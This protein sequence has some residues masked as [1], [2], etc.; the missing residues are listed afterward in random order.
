V[1][2]LFQR[3]GDDL[4]RLALLL[5]A[6][7]QQAEQALLATAHSALNATSELGELELA[8]ML[9]QALPAERQR[10][11]RSKRPTWVGMA[12][13]KPEQR[14]LLE[15]LAALPRAQRLVLGL[16]L[17][18]TFEVNEVA[19]LL[20]DNQVTAQTHYRDALVALL[21]HSSADLHPDDLIGD[22][23]PQAC[24]TT[25][26]ALMSG[27][28]R[29]HADADVRG[30]L[31]LCA[32]CREF[33]R[34]WQILTT[35]VEQVL[36]NALRERRLPQRLITQFHH[37]ELLRPAWHSNPTVRMILATLIVLAIIAA[38]MFPYG[39]QGQATPVQQSTN[40][41]PT[42]LTALLERAQQ[43]LYQLTPGEGVWHGRYSIQWWFPSG[44]QAMLD[45]NLWLE[46]STGRHRIQ[47]VHSSGGGPYEFEL[48]DGTGTIWY[49]INS[50][51]APSIFPFSY[52][53]RLTMASIDSMTEQ[54]QEML[55][56]RLASGPWALPAI[57][58]RQ[59]LAA[60][61]LRLWGR[62][63]NENGSMNSL[64]SFVSHSPLDMP[65]GAQDADVGEL[66]ILLTVDENT[67]RLQEI[68]ELYGPSGT[69]Q[70]IRSVWRIEE[71][72]WLPAPDLSLFNIGQAWNGT[73]TF[74]PLEE[75][76]HPQVPLQGIW[77]LSNVAQLPLQEIVYLPMF[78]QAPPGTDSA[79]LLQPNA[80]SDDLSLHRGAPL[81]RY[82]GEGRQVELL[83]GVEIPSISVVF[84]FEETLRVGEWDVA[85]MPQRP[86]TYWARITPLKENFIGSSWL[87]TRGYSRDEVLELIE[88]LGPISLQSIMSQV[89][90][91]SDRQPRTPVFDAVIQALDTPDYQHDKV[92]HLLEQRGYRLHE[93]QP[94]LAPFQ[95]SHNFGYEALMQ[96]EV[97]VHPDQQFSD[98]LRSLTGQLLLLEEV[99]DQQHIQYSSEMDAYGVTAI[100]S[101]F[102][103]TPQ[104]E[105]QELLLRMLYCGP[106]ELQE[107]ADGG[108]TLRLIESNWQFQSCMRPL[109]PL[110]L[111][112]Q[113]VVMMSMDNQPSLPKLD[114]VADRPLSIWA[115]LNA[116]GRLE[117]IEVR[118]G[119]QRDDLL[120]ESWEIITNEWVAPDEVPANAFSPEIPS[121][122][123]N[124]SS[125]EEVQA[126]TMV[127][128]DAIRLTQGTLYG[129][130]SEIISDTTIFTTTL[131]EISEYHSMMLQ[132][133]ELTNDTERY[134]VYI[135]QGPYRVVNGY[136][137]LQSITTKTQS[138]TLQFGGREVQAW[139]ILFGTPQTVI[140]MNDTMFI[141]ASP[142]ELVQPILD[143]LQLLEVP[144]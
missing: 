55:Q 141:I 142:P 98:Q 74:D 106:A 53:R 75:R 132:T 32:N 14:P 31:A 77:H 120:L 15:A 109:Y 45:G 137:R 50:A 110:Q 115:D 60:D 138:I 89:Q 33:E 11:R 130:P 35:E 73:G 123:F 100:T 91:F 6:D 143:A 114:D 66:E 40:T 5:A 84:E 17:L 64:I 117:R 127:L 87:H 58:L 90:M 54:Q 37:P 1:D 19:P 24:R 99:I 2:Q 125:E 83:T 29:T 67:G 88:T 144:E 57:Y 85:L 61:D 39:R 8:L 95:V 62:Q 103:P 23:L 4:Y 44:S 65:V 121:A 78:R 139:Q 70:V 131:L 69:E 119:E 105:W 122:T 59:A 94:D 38:L 63:R 30:H 34:N 22:E 56:A 26:A 10:W 71:E 104:I 108:Q 111:N 76:S 101:R 134:T 51:Y 97:W 49:A 116:E 7:E 13:I 113:R 48:G 107:R 27:V 42:D 43:Q 135:T 9:L 68:R 28:A 12:D 140:E 16:T 21:P 124:W 86:N 92:Y 36:R 20:D 41:A 46:P 81:W 52:D 126:H 72:G 79:L 128:T 18:R 129:L 93:P 3:Y 112:R 82:M 102:K 133:Y 136:L 47:L 96:H 25:R 118:A 80:P